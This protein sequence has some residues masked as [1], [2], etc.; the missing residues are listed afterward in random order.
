MY[1]SIPGII[2]P[3]HGDQ[4]QV[5]IAYPSKQPMKGGLI[6]YRAAKVRFAIRSQGYLHS[7]ERLRPERRKMSFDSNLIKLFLAPF[8]I[9]LVHP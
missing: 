1:V 2:D 7:I 8:S 9:H 5:E 3:V 6:R 4:D